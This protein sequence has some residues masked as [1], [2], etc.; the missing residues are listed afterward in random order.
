MKNTL[1][2]PACK[3]T[4][5]DYA[6]LLSQAVHEDRAS[7][8]C[9][10]D[11]EG[12]YTLSLSFRDTTSLVQITTISCGI[13]TELNADED[14]QITH[15]H[16][17]DGTVH[18]EVTKSIGFDV[19]VSDCCQLGIGEL[20]SSIATLFDKHNQRVASGEITQDD[21][22]IYSISRSL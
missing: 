18:E 6:L 12:L 7:F 16:I 3:P 17:T 11:D 15:V 1:S 5:T 20:Q 10:I 4:N 2:D 14:G 22:K 8:R 13:A 21:T 9:G 19:L